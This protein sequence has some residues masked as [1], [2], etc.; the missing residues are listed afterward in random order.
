MATIEA[1]GNEP[2]LTPAETAARYRVDVK[3]VSRWADKGL[4]H[5]LRTPGGHRRFFE[6][7]V[8]AQQRGEPWVLPAEY[9]RAA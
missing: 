7:E 1:P 2:L 6:N 3:T 5:E 4:L 8:S 9:R